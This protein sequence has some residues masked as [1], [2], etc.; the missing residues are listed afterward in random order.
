MILKSDNEPT[1]LAHQRRVAR[2]VK[3]GERTE[4]FQEENP[5]GYDSQSDSGVE[6]G[7]RVL[8]GMFI[9]LKL[10][11]ESRQPST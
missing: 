2:L 5:T 9:T 3:M 6:I 11:L 1:V 7:V 4:N 10:C 8:R